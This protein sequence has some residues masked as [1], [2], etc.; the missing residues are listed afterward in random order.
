MVIASSSDVEFYEEQVSY[1]FMDMNN[2]N[3]ENVNV[4]P[5]ELKIDYRLSTAIN[6]NCSFLGFISAQRN[7]PFYAKNIG[8]L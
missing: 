4:D 8:D 2:V 6:A 1:C 7:V 5:T 3:F